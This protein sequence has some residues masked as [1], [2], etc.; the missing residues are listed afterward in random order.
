MKVRL[1]CLLLTIILLAPLTATAAASSYRGS[2]AIT[3]EVQKTIIKDFSGTAACEP[4]EITMTDDMVNIPVIAVKVATMDTGHSERDEDM[5]KMFEHERFPLITGDTEAFAANEFLTAEH[6]N[7][8]T[9]EEVRFALTIR[10]ITQEI[11]A[12][13]TKP[14]IDPSSITATLLFDLSLSSFELDPPTFLGVIK[15][16]DTLQVRVTMS[17]DINPPTQSRSE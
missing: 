16:K 15:V 14:Q 3:F 11:T 9:P 6:K 5:R 13:V 17:F 7:I 4:F 1:C 12:T 2:C 10:D 8:R